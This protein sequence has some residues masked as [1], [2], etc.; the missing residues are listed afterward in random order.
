M[1]VKKNLSNFWDIFDQ[2][3]G[4]ILPIWLLLECFD[5][6]FFLVKP[7]T[8]H[9]SHHLYAQGKP[10][11]VLLRCPYFCCPLTWK[12]LPL[13]VSLL[14]LYLFFMLLQK[15]LCLLSLSWFS[16]WVQFPLPLNP[17]VVC[18]YPTSYN[19]RL[20][21]WE[22]EGGRRGEAEEDKD[23]PHNHTRSHI[24]SSFIDEKIEA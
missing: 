20:W 12:A 6:S 19:N 14:K 4:H 7:L 3:R 8:S 2:T 11:L 9:H 17:M 22:G 18:T 24:I 23:N 21:W 1:A 5:C 13:L 16:S 15:Y 10:C